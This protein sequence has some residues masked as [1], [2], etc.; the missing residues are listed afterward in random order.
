MPS[1]YNQQT[2]TIFPR[3][4]LLFLETLILAA[5]AWLL[6]LQGPRRLNDWFHVGLGAG[7]TDR[8][9]LL[10]VLI[11][12]VYARMLFTL[13]YLLKRAVPW[14]EAFAVPLAFALYYVG[15][16]LLSQQRESALDGWDALFAALFLAGSFINTYSELQRDRW[17]RRLENKGKLYASGLFRHCAHI[18]YFGDLLWVLALALLTRNLWSLAIPAALFGLFAFYNIPMLD[19]HLESKYGED[20]RLYRKQT[21]K[22]IPYIY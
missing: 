8:N 6:L 2:N 13:F 15:F 11:A 1:L 14:Q 10:F 5:S 7:S 9:V 22:L 19:R 12:F 16:P 17:K 3:L 20:F 4:T 18:N 21:S